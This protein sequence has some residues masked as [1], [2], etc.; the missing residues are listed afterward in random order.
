VRLRGFPGNSTAIGAQIYATLHEGASEERTLRRDAN[1]NAGTFHQSDLPVH[2][3]LGDATQIDA[4]RVVWPNGSE[5]MV[6]AATVSQEIA[7]IYDAPS[8][9]AGVLLN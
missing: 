9:P 4:L 6:G 8:T 3:G 5:Q 7:V 1:A 2:F